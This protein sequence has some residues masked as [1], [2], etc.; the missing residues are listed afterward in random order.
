LA[1]EKAR[2]FARSSGINNAKGW[3]SASKNGKLPDGVPSNPV[4]TYQAEGWISWGDWLGTGRVADNEKEYW[5]YKTAREFVH[6]LGLKDETEWY[7]YCKSGN[8]PP[9][10]P[11]AVRKTYKDKGWKGMGDWLG[12]DT[13]ANQQRVLEEAIEY[14]R[15]LG[16]N[17]TEEWRDFTKSGKL[18]K[19]IPADPANVYK[20]RLERHGR[21]AWYWKGCLHARAIPLSQLIVH[22]N[23]YQTGIE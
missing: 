22:D 4:Q 21:L 5:D 16:L 7:S 20:E 2:E 19:S 14:A 18:L 23:L 10:I 1:I 8:K 12:T 3:F 6:K 11:T 17:T 15:A 13:I 9:Q